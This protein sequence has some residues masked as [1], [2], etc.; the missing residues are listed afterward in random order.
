MTKTFFKLVAACWL[1][2]FWAGMVHA[3]NELVFGI[4]PLLSPSQTV[5]RFAPLKEHLSTA[6][7]VPVTL[8]S[9]PDF[10]KFIDRTRAGEYDIIFTAPH[11][12]RLAEKRDGYRRIAM[13]GDVTV[14]T[15]ARKGGPVQALADLKGR[16]L[17]VGARLSMTYQI[18]NHVLGRHGLA[19]DRDVMFVDPASF[20]NVIEAVMRGEADAGATISQLW[21]N[22]APEQRENLRE[23]HRAEPTPGFLILAHARLPA[24]ILKQLELA[25]LDFKNTEA[26]KAY[27]KKTQQVD[28]RPLDATTMQ[29][30]DPYTT[31][32]EKQ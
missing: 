5:E 1:L 19:I 17:A 20:S 3:A 27:F 31:V 22:A 28:F 14:V 25:F 2:P 13:T 7:G 15:L 8:R 32:L 23:I 24:E 11:M 6:L 21:D 12:G 18:L 26:G 9:A 4:Y 10:A 16:T 29:R 30:I